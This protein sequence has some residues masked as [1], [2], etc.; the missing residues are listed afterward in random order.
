MT[1]FFSS[2]LKHMKPYVPGEQP[3]DQ[4][5]VKL[6]TNESPFPPSQGVLDAVNGETG[7]MNLYS[8]PELLI[9]RQRLARRYGVGVE[10]VLLTNGSDEA[11]HFIILSYGDDETPFVFPDVTY[12]LY[13]V[14]CRLYGLPFAEIPLK[15][16]FT[17]DLDAFSKAKGH[18]I[19]ANPNAPTG[20]ALTR[21]EIRDLARGN[22]GR[23]VIVDEAYVDFGGESCIPLTRELPNLLVVQTYSKSRSLA[24]ARLGFIIGPAALMA[25]INAVR[26]SINPYNVNRMSLAAAA[27]AIDDDGYYM[28]NCRKIAETRQW[29]KEQLAALGFE[30]LP[31]SANFLFAAPPD[32]DGEKYYLALKKRGVLVRHFSI[33][34]ILPFVRI[35]IG[36][37]E[38]MQILI[39]QTQAILKEAQP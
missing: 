25:E 2:R 27:A 14:L 13:P 28:A 29:A 9:A 18:V 20:I 11:L 7:K 8:D 1:A 17:V 21:D 19:L 23:L 16:D 22:P 35:S 31:S 32:R 26:C 3:R 36:A 34:R 38:E 10:N 6:N 37:K 39:R 12:G 24:G 33:P 30:V 5:Y 4:Q 15:D